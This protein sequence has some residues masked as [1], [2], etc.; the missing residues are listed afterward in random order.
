M[1][2][3]AASWSAKIVLSVLVVASPVLAVA[4]PGAERPAHHSARSAAPSPQPSGNPAS[5]ADLNAAI[6]PLKTTS[7][8]VTMITNDSSFRGSVE[9]SRHAAS[10]V[11]EAGNLHLAEVVDNGKVWLKMDLG[12]A[13]NRQLGISGDQWMTLDPSKLA[14]DNNLPIQV[15]GSDPIDM[16]GIL[17]GVTSVTRVN[18]T[19][20]KGTM[21]LGKVQGHNTPDPDAVRQAGT[22]AKSAPY[23]L[24]TDP[25]GRI[26]A[27]AV[28]TRSFDPSL[29]VEV[30]YTRYGAASPIT[31]PTNAIPAPDSVYSVFN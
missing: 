11:A 17:A 16:P 24:T 25:Q 12:A 5:V 26:T 30:G 6:A 4:L 8:D 9:P 23:A 29:S 3:F 20:F 2:I 28:D 13:A 18:P 1:R 27:F 22:P 19:Q 14:T 10:L 15:D 7:H 21:D 31:E